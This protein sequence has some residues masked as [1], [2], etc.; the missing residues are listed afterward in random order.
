MNTSP[1]ITDPS[2]YIFAIDLIITRLAKI[3]DIP[4]G[5]L[6]WEM[7]VRSVLTVLGVDYSEELANFSKISH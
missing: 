2:Q 7:A 5:Y 4:E 3:G 1:P 6:A